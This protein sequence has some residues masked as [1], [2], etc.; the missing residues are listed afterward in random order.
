VIFEHIKGKDNTLPD[1]FLRSSILQEW[2]N[3][4]SPVGMN[5]SVLVLKIS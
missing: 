2:R 1:I 3:E 4:H 5:I